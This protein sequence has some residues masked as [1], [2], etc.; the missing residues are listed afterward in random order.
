MYTD[1]VPENSDADSSLGANWFYR[2]ENSLLPIRALSGAYEYI[3]HSHEGKQVTLYQP[4][5]RELCASD[6][7]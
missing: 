7:Q 6:I 4:E 3:L 5:D 1:A 2:S